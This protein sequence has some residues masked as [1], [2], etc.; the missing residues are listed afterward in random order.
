[1]HYI[2]FILSLYFCFQGEG[3]YDLTAAYDFFRSRQDSTFKLGYSSERQARLTKLFL[4]FSKFNSRTGK[5]EHDYSVF[6][7]GQKY[8]VCERVFA[9]LHGFTKTAFEKEAQTQKGAL[10]SQVLENEVDDFDDD[11]DDNDDVQ[12]ISHSSDFFSLSSVYRDD[13]LHPFSILEHEEIFMENVRGTLNM[14]IPEF[15]R[16][17][18]TP[19]A[20]KQSLCIAW[21]DEYFKTYSDHSPNSLLSKV[22]L[23][24]K[25][26]LY[27]LYVRAMKEQ[28]VSVVTYQ[29]FLK[30]WQVLFPYC[31]NRPWCNVPGKCET[32]FMIQQARGV[33]GLDRKTALM[34]QKCHS[35]H[36]GGLFMLERAKYKERILYALAEKTRRM[37]II[38][39]GMDQSHCQC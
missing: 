8:F 11:D 24:F 13:T 5:W 15:T 18:M 1:M 9:D 20:E 37:S 6:Y 14:K 4:E 27:D 19:L 23:T 34:L 3:N 17:A 21:L 30:L 22:S 16:C 25:K 38:I 39:D 26:D 7:S 12:E 32:C 35:I 36:R 31:I 28:S 33:N 10:L 29:R 2:N